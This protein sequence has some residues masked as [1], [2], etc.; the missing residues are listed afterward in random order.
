[1]K[2]CQM[3]GGKDVCLNCNDGF[4]FNNETNACETAIQFNLMCGGNSCDVG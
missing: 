1:M 2:N 4:Y 3:A